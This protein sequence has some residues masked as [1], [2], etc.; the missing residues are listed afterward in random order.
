MPRGLIVDLAD[1]SEFRQ[2]LA[3]RPPRI[4]HGTALLLLILLAA[5]VTW[6]ALVEA[7]LVVRAAGRVRPV[8][9]PTRVF[10]S[11]S[12]DL[13]GRVVEAPFDEGDVVRKGDV[14][15]R[16]DTAHIDNRSPSSNRTIEASQDELDQAHG[17]GKAARAAAQL[18]REKKPRP[19][20][21]R[22]RRRWPAPPAAGPPK[23]VAARPT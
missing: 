12:A 8:E 23:S 15:V 20:W 13:E 9:I 6:A 11:A 7:N 4:V 5:A 3:A 17:P 1:C 2:T 18:R 21:P 14:L 16:L 10:T 22:P 19:S